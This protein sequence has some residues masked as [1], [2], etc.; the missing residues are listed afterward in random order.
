MKCDT[1]VMLS[2]KLL[3][4]IAQGVCM[5]SVCVCMCGVCVVG[6]VCVVGVGVMCSV[7]ICSVCSVCVCVCFQCWGTRNEVERV[8][9]T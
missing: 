7:C 9:L 1:H 4:S 8:Q 3:H 2:H 6:S 5:C